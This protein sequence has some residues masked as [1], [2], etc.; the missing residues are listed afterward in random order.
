[1]AYHLELVEADH[2]LER[3]AGYAEGLLDPI[4]SGNASD[5]EES[6]K[7]VQPLDGMK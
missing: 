3:G 6:T 7:K 5:C 4:E 1:V 2:E